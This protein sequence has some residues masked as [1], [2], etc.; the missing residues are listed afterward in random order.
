M[1]NAPEDDNSRNSNG[2]VKIICR[3]ILRFLQKNFTILQKNFTIFAEK[4]YDSCRKILRSLEENLMIFAKKGD[5]SAEKL[6]SFSGK[7]Y[8]FYKKI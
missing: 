5:N 3:K 6:D 7:F 1:L 4:F 2:T 8:D